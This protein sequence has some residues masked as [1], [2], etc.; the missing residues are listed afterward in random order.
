MKYGEYEGFKNAEAEDMTELR[1]SRGAQRT[2]NLFVEVSQTK[3]K[4]KPLYSLKSYHQTDEYPSA[5]LIYMASVDETDAALK[6]VG[7]L[8]HWRKL[9]KLKWFRDGRPE[10]AFE[11][12]ESWRRDMADRDK[13]EAKRVLLSQCRED[14]VTAARA[15]EKLATEQS[16]STPKSSKK[17]EVS[18]ED[19]TFLELVDN[20]RS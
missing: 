14:N 1:D 5:Y 6:I 11:G 13:S 18:E 19:S 2:E 20:Y 15:L 16:K 3:D 12:V 7:S 17:S 8:A 10:H 9:C 4:Y